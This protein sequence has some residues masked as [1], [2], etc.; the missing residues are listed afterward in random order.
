MLDGLADDIVLTARR[1][2]SAGRLPRCARP[3]LLDRL[4][5]CPSGGELVAGGFRRDVEV[6]AELDSSTVVPV[7]TDG[8]FRPG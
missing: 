6:A 5:G 4:L 3:H 7:L 2:G 1:A 8:A